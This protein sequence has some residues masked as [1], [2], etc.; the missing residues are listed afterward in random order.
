MVLCV[1]VVQDGTAILEK[2]QSLETGPLANILVC[3]G[4]AG[5]VLEIRAIRRTGPENF[6]SVM[7]KTLGARYGQEPV[8]MAGVFV[9]VQGK[10]KIHVMVGDCG[11][12]MS[13]KKGK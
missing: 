5:K 10:A 11:T 4:E 12:I 8:A 13:R 2:F 9:I 6:V 7:R 1:F 3:G